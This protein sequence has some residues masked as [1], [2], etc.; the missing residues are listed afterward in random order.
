MLSGGDTVFDEFDF[1]EEDEEQPKKRNKP[2]GNRQRWSPAEMDE[3]NRYFKENI[4]TLTTPGMKAC[5]KAIQLSKNK[6]GQ[7]CR[8]SW[9]SIKK[10]IWN[11]I[12]KKK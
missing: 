1:Q 8:R 3:L 5:V 9:E 4:E 12:Q 10:K 7:I 11:M 6:N 2:T